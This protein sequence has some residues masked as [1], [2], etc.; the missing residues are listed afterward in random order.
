[1][2][3]HSTSDVAGKQVADPDS[4]VGF[5]L[6]GLGK[7]GFEGF[8]SVGEL[9]DPRLRREIPDAPGVYIVL[10][11]GDEP[12]EF[13][14]TSTGGWFTLSRASL[15]SRE[16]RTTVVFCV[17]VFRI[18]RSSIWLTTNLSSSAVFFSCSSTLRFRDPIPVT[19]TSDTSG[20][21]SRKMTRTT[22]ASHRA[23]PSPNGPQTVIAAVSP[24]SWRQILPASPTYVAETIANA[25]TASSPTSAHRA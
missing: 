16:L 12:P 1:M 3:H 14:E 19:L 25:A 7:A 22:S 2:E 11:M 6:T 21:K 15:R 9:L 24:A 18:D 23:S 8:R 4:G 17:W 5:T 20:H 13:L 10:Y